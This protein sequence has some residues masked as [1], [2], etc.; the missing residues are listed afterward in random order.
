MDKREPALLT[1]VG[2]VRSGSTF[3]EGR[4]A[5]LFNGVAVGELIGTWG[6]FGQGNILCSCGAPAV[7]CPFWAAVRK[8]YPGLSRPATIEYMTKVNIDLMSV[9]RI[10]RWNAIV[11]GNKRDTRFTRESREL[12]QAV[13]EVAKQEGFQMVIDSSK[14]PLF[15]ALANQTPIQGFSAQYCARL[16]RDPRGVSYSLAHPK[17]EPTADGRHNMKGYTYL[18][19]IPF[20]IA[21]NEFADRVAPRDAGRFRYEDFGSECFR[22][23]IRARGLVES[24]KLGG[25]RHQLVANPVRQSVPSSFRRDDRWRHQQPRRIQTLSALITLPWMRRYGYTQTFRTQGPKPVQRPLRD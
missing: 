21:M 23:W 11:R 25:A 13:A 4:V 16:V 20:W 12:L 8:I 9:R 17:S 24:P 3:F 2:M 14:H 5:A 10:H 19:S 18:R 22:G 6:A 7:A 15:Y 1:L